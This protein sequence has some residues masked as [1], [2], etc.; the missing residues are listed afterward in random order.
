[1]PFHGGQDEGTDRILLPA[2]G[3]KF[4]LLQNCR[5][6]RVGRIAVRPQ[7]T[8]VFSSSP[9][10]DQLATYKDRL[11]LLGSRYF[12]MTAVT[13]A[14]SAGSVSAAPISPFSS[15]ENVWQNPSGAAARQFDVAYNTDTGKFHYMGIAG[16]AGACFAYPDQTGSSAPA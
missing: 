16:A 13:D 10:L 9:I 1:M 6:D 11:I 7:F 8:Q 5:L 15:V 4:R 2:D 14:L 3:T 12:L